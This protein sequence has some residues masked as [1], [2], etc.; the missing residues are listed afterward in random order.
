MFRVGIGYDI[1][2]LVKGRKLFLGG[3]NIPSSRGL[4]GHS[5]ADVLLHALCDAL[6]GACAQKDIGEHF[7][8]SHSAYKNISS[9]KLLKK[10]NSILK[11]L[12]YSIGNIDTVIVAEGPRLGPFKAKMCR[13]IARALGISCGQVNVKA[14]TTEGTG[15]IG[16]GEVISAYA[17]ALIKKI[18]SR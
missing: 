18:A 3:V 4:S 10:V 8:D 9:I 5:D 7:P 12:K 13:K 16:R 1:H 15:P 17:T 6:L 11:K 2:R 14:T